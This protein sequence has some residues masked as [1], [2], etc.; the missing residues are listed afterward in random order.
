MSQQQGEMQQFWHSS[1]GANRRTG[2]GQARGQ[3][4]ALDETN[5]NAQV[6]RELTGNSLSLRAACRMLAVNEN[7]VELAANAFFQLDDSAVERL[8]SAEESRDSE[9]DGHEVFVPAEVA[10]LPEALTWAKYQLESLGCLARFIP[11]P[12]GHETNTTKST[13]T[14]ATYLST[15]PCDNAAV[16]S[17]DKVP[18]VSIDTE[19]VT[20]LVKREKAIHSTG[21]FGF[22]HKVASLMT[23][24]KQLA[25]G[26]LAGS[27]QPELPKEA[28]GEVPVEGVAEPTPQQMYDA[29]KYQYTVALNG[30]EWACPPAVL[31]LRNEQARSRLRVLVVDDAEESVEGSHEPLVLAANTA[32]SKMRGFVRYGKV[33][34][35]QAYVSVLEGMFPD[36]KVFHTTDGNKHTFVACGIAA[37]LCAN[38][39]SGTLVYNVGIAP[40]V[41]SQTEGL[42][43]LM[44]EVLTEAGCTFFFLRKHSEGSVIGVLG[45]QPTRGEA[46][47]LIESHEH[48]GEVILRIPPTLGKLMVSKTDELR[49]RLGCKVRVEGG[50]HVRVAGKDESLAAAR[51][52]IAKLVVFFSRE[53]QKSRLQD[54]SKSLTINALKVQV[55]VKLPERMR[56]L[57][58]QPT[59][60][61]WKNML[62]TGPLKFIEPSV[63]SSQRNAAIVW[64][65]ADAVANEIKQLLVK[66]HVIAEPDDF[67][68]GAVPSDIRVGDVIEHAEG[69][70]AEGGRPNRL[71]IHELVSEQQ[72]FKRATVIRVEPGIQEGGQHF[73]SVMSDWI[74]CSLDPTRPDPGRPSCDILVVK[75]EQKGKQFSQSIPC[76]GTKM[77]VK[78]QSDR[79]PHAVLDCARAVLRMWYASEVDET[80]FACLLTAVSTLECDSARRKCTA[81]EA[82][83]QRCKEL[84]Q[85]IDRDHDRFEQMLQPLPQGNL[86]EELAS[87]G[88]RAHQDRSHS[89]RIALWELGI[90]INKARDACEHES[91]SEK[92]DVSCLEAIQQVSA[93]TEAYIDYTAPQEHVVISGSERNVRTAVRQVKDI[94]VTGAKGLDDRH[95]ATLS[96]D[97]AEKLQENHGF[98][99]KF[100]AQ[101]TGLKEAWMEGTTLILVGTAAGVEQALSYIGRSTA[102]RGAEEVCEACL[103]DSFG[104]EEEDN[105][106]TELLCGHRVHYGCGAKAMLA[107][108]SMSAEEGAARAPCRCPVASCG[109][110]LTPHEYS[111]LYEG[112]TTSKATL[113]APVENIGNIVAQLVHTEEMSTCPSC[114]K[115]VVTSSYTEPLSCTHC[116]FSFCGQRNAPCGG[117]PHYF[118]TCDQFV[119][120]REQHTGTTAVAKV[121]PDNVVNCAKCPAWILRE[122]D[123]GDERCRYMKCRQCRYEFCWLCL[124]PA[125][126]HRHHNPYNPMEN[127]ECDPQNRG[128]RRERLSKAHEV[129]MWN[130]YVSCERCGDTY[131]SSSTGALYGCLQCLNRYACAKCAPSGCTKD[132]AHVMAVVPTEEPP[133]RLA[134]GAACLRGHSLV[135]QD[136]NGKLSCDKCGKN[137]GPPNF[138]GCTLCNYH[139]CR[140]CLE[141]AR[142]GGEVLG[143][144]S[145]SE[146]V[147]PKEVWTHTHT[148]TFK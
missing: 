117:V 43:E 32:V 110:T 41:F 42:A 118:T 38:W 69:W 67:N 123:L 16:E 47:A 63:E 106:M 102:P 21:G 143:D 82:C 128:Q 109:H 129:T 52:V 7:S 34:H 147:I 45:P 3:A 35:L 79:E 70:P 37:E 71:M 68:V 96:A 65:S 148:H 127:V 50:G 87:H 57:L 92:W 97:D 56:E 145:L 46:L 44:Q 138:V 132:A 72:S 103:M 99:M 24:L 59:S 80:L 10:L 84:A 60:G 95:E 107:I 104:D 15:L 12:R 142:P 27:V 112:C 121:L 5:E 125:L 18:E 116:G 114:D 139:I 9:D 1:S 17:C 77:L 85:E 31:K 120:A 66:E 90:H 122:D 23:D 81:L 86:R 4:G 126:D 115:W 13:F 28:V 29:A 54:V 105:K 100:I 11:K 58:S 113:P 119:R 146:V 14:S 136:G 53:V 64:A 83:R 101:E 94:L 39:L 33:P 25:S 133:T 131:D 61:N 22:E 48:V 62:K 6:L 19:L 141:G 73:R 89:C 51:D 2:R 124:G 140:Q 55:K 93:H 134:E 30:D 98:L 74:M 130:G 26:K 111:A 49:E 36:T 88:K 75:F 108:H 137:G 91:R 76:P 40:R 135:D 78:V 20:A 8:N 144:R